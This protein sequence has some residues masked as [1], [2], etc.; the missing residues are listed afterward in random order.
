ML[1]Q[2]E[3]T[4]LIINA[5]FVKIILAFPRELVIDSGNSAWIQVLY[6]SV[7]ALLLFII[8]AAIYKGKKNIIELAYSCGG[9]PLK[10]ITGLLTFI[11]LFVN[12]VPIARIFPESVNIILLQDMETKVILIVFGI[13]AAIGAYLGI[14]SVARI[15]SIFLPAAAAVL[16]I[17]LLLLIPYYDIKNITP[18]F[19]KGYSNIFLK[20][21]NSLSMYSDIILLNILLPF[22]KN[23]GEI[24]KSGYK[25]LIIAGIVSVVIVFAYCLTYQYPASEEFIIPVYQLAKI[26][27]LSSFFSRFESFFQFVWSIMIFLYAAFYIYM[28]CYV[29]LI[30]FNLKFYRPLILPITVICFGITLLPS[31]VMD[32]FNYARRINIMVYPLA[33]VLPLLYGMYSRKEK[34]HEIN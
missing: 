26:I 7:C 30:T 10:I 19:G 4:C 16:V 13:A 9:K 31:S 20:G 6:N 29:W 24:K 1:K 25:A 34:K 18:F 33:F 14:E 11:V 28:M 32:M 27:H 5:I 8:T 17:F 23:S 15:H 2:K 21:F 12:F 3:I 22:S